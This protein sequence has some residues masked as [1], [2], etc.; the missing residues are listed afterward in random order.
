MA[1]FISSSDLSRGLPEAGRRER[2]EC[3]GTGQAAFTFRLCFLFDGARL[4]VFGLIIHS[5]G[6]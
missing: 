4:P 3:E 2:S 1:S 5:A 6:I